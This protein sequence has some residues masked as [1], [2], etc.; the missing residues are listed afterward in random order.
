VGQPHGSAMSELRLA[1][2]E[3]CYSTLMPWLCER[4]DVLE[5][6]HST[7]IYRYDGELGVVTTKVVMGIWQGSLLERV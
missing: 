5:G 6:A 4:A 7:P 3:F 1:A 2:D